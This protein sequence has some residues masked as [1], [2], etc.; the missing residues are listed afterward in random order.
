M[1]WVTIRV[2][3]WVLGLLAEAGER[4][5][6]ITHPGSSKLLPLSSGDGWDGFE[7]WSRKECLYQITPHGKPHNSRGIAIVE[8]TAK[9][10]VHG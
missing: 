10:T 2:N 1:L 5:H 9:R 3:E 7:E 8:N 4:V 6:A